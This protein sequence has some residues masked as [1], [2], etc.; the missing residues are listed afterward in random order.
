MNLTNRSS[1]FLP[2]D[3]MIGKMADRVPQGAV[4]YAPMANEPSK[5]YLAVHGVWNRWL[6]LDEPWADPP[7][8]TPKN[9]EHFCRENNVS[10][11]VLPNDRWAQLTLSRWVLDWIE[12]NETQWLQPVEKSTWGSEYLVLYELSSE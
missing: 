5:F 1:F 10:Y 6:W 2:Y 12:R 9:L 3:D 8:Q 11:V 7:V 4:I